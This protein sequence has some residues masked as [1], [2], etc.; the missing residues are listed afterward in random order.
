MMARLRPL[1]ILGGLCVAWYAFVQLTG[2]P[3]YLLP[4]PLQVF[5]VMYRRAGYLGENAL[6]TLAE[7]VL[8]LGLGAALGILT[9]L[10][11]ARFVAARRWLLPLVVVSQAIPVFALAPLFVLWFGYGMA[12]KV[13]VACVVIFFPV[14]SAFLDGLR[15]TDRG[16]IDLAQVMGASPWRML[17]DV[18]LPAA[19]PALASGLRLAA[20]IAPIAAV[21]G[22]W[23]GA[24]AGLGFVMLQANGR[25]QIDLMFAALLV[26]AL[27]A[28][29]L[30]YA[31]DALLR[32][33]V[34]WQPVTTPTDD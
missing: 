3:P 23:V 24:G 6:Y 33:L 22:E 5:G 4:D 26:L 20:A 1:V 13:A 28:V 2:V 21:I 31:T 15:R 16:W 27:M 12:S 25:L 32:R 18:R 29:A 34:P 10:S 17:I 14:A 11:L 9:A 7:I 19:L 8:G 30:Y